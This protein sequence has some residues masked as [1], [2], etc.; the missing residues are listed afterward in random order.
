MYILLYIILDWKIE[1]RYMDWSFVEDVYLDIYLE[2]T[3]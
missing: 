2:Y 3:N 1:F